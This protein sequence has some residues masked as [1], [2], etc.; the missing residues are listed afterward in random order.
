MLTVLSASI[1]VLMDPNLLVSIMAAAGTA[2]GID[3]GAALLSQTPQ[4][5]GLL[6][7]TIISFWR[8]WVVP[9]PFWQAE[10]DDKFAALEALQEQ[11]EV[12]KEL[13][14]AVFQL[15]ESMKTVEIFI[16]ALPQPPIE[17]TSNSPIKPKSEVKDG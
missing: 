15:S 10:R 8:G 17:D 5:L 4:F 1:F 9:K 6:A 7:F 12:N 11:N 14:E 16:Q 3:I 13:A 2:G